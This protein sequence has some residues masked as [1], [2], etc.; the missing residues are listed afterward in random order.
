[1]KLPSRPLAAAF[2]LG[3]LFLWSA[4]SQ[5]RRAAPAAHAAHAATGI[6]TIRFAHTQLEPGVREAY[7]DIITAYEALHPHIRVEQIAV[8]LRAWPAWVQT[9]LVGRNAPDLLQLLTNDPNPIQRYFQ[10]ITRWATAPNPYNAGTPLADLPWHATFVIPG[11]APPVY[12]PNFLDYYGIPQ[13]F[14]TARVYYNASRWREWTGRP[15]P[16]AD[17]RE[18]LAAAAAIHDEARRRNLAVIP[19]AGSRTNARPLL[20]ELFG[21]VQHTTLDDRDYAATNEV[22]Y[23]AAASSYARRAWTVHDAPFQTGLQIMQEVGAV[24]QPGFLQAERDEALFLFAQERALML[25]AGAAEYGSIK[26]DVPFELGVFALALPT[27]ADPVYGP[28]VLGRNSEASAVLRGAFALTKQSAAPAA[29]IDFL[30]F[31]TSRDIHARFTR[32]S[33]WLPVIRG[34]APNPEIAAFTP[35]VE[36]YPGGQHPGIGIEGQRYWNNLIFEL[37]TPDGVTRVTTAL[38]RAYPGLMISSIDKEAR[39]IPRAINNLERLVLAARLEPA[40]FPDLAAKQS[41]AREAQLHLELN[42]AAYDLD[43]AHL[44]G[45]IE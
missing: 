21:V 23:D 40:T 34:V 44:R 4:V 36:G 16:P 29:A 25:V 10:P 41:E 28:Y 30:Q 3:A 18:F 32:A 20:D 27:P 31:L 19:M 15:D 17:Y 12:W 2:V 38:E 43:R 5:L 26:R 6:T 45:E 11:N 8:P 22:G 42:L 1:M 7:D 13:T 37:F 33:G 39:E 9:R 35:A 14:F 24:F